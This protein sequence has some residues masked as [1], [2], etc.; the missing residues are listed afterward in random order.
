LFTT[1]EML[2]DQRK[3]ILERLR[4]LQ[5]ELVCEL[6]SLDL[7][8]QNLGEKSPAISFS[9][10]KN[11]IDAIVAY[12]SKIMRPE[13]PEAIAK[14]IVDGGW[15][16]GNPYALKNLRGSIKYHLDNSETT[17]ALKRFSSGRV[18]LYSWPPDFDRG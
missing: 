8:L 14:V 6:E 18:G 11:A 17:K 2:T 7:A 5:P 13:D 4:A 9:A 3:V 16:E 12:L 1:R 10:Y 15:L